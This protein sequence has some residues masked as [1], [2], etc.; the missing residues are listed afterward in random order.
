[1]KRPPGGGLLWQDRVISMLEL[2]ALLSVPLTVLAMTWAACRFTG[3]S[4]WF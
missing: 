1:M 4:A 3:K 2:Y